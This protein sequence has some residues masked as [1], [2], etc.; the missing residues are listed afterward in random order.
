MMH[1]NGYVKK[2]PVFLFTDQVRTC[3]CMS[4]YT[5]AMLTRRDVAE[6]LGRSVATVRRMEGTRLHPQVAARGIRLFDPDEIAALAKEVQKTGRALSPNQ[7][8]VPDNDHLTCEQYDELQEQLEAALE[9]GR[10]LRA[11]LD[12]ATDQAESK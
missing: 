10:D 2:Q 11:L 4:R 5:L 6:K 7:R 8:T 12:A 3:T 1:R 9:E